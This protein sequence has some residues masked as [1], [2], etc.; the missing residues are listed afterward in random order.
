V[1]CERTAAGTP[2]FLGGKLQCSGILGL[3]L[4]PSGGRLRH[5][6][7]LKVPPKEV[8]RNPIPIRLSLALGSGAIRP[9]TGA[10]TP[11][12]PAIQH[13]PRFLSIGPTTTDAPETTSSSRHGLSYPRGAQQI[14]QGLNSEPA[15]A[16]ATSR[17]SCRMEFVILADVAS[18]V[19]AILRSIAEILWPWTGR[20]SQI[21]L[22]QQTK[23]RELRRPNRKTHDL[24]SFPVPRWQNYD[25]CH[26]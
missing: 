16:P 4:L 10:S 17:C 25:I 23:S 19:H 11:T 12:S 21:K 13:R 3:D 1:C 15:S 7:S 20:S 26:D 14:Q 22:T 6:N 5:Q 8:S 2:L 9:A 24:G 18:K